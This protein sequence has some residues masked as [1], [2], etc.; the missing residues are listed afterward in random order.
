MYTT[1]ISPE[2]LNQSIGRDTIILD[3]RFDLSDS[4]KGRQTYQA[5]HLPGAY[6]IG[7][8]QDLSAPVTPTSGR[9]P[10]PELASFVEK[11]RTC[12]VQPSSQVVAY[13]SSGGCYAARAWWLIKALGHDSVA[14]LNGGFTKWS[15]A[16]FAIDRRAPNPATGKIKA[17]SNWLL[18]FIEDEQLFTSYQSPDYCLIDARD[19]ARYKGELEPIDP[20]PGH[21]PGAINKPWQEVIDEQGYFKPKEFHQQR[22]QEAGNATQ[23]H[24]CG[25][26]VTACVNVF[27]KFIADGEMPLLYPGS[28]SQWCSLHP[29]TI[30]TD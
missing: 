10:L 19:N 30:E 11:M 29:D 17:P 4:E 8:N 6:Y 16:G 2:E 27:S 20:I 24:Y 7:L 23:V 12:G 28:W 1:L 3:C 26:G 22:W 13:D 25:S 15:E 18:P 21:I 14:V 9:H 5:G